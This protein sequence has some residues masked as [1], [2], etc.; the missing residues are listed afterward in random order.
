MQYRKS[1]KFAF[2]LAEVLITLGIIGVVAALTIPALLRQ[3]Q[4]QTTV[5]ILK[6]QHS[7]WANAYT[8]AVQENDTP[9]NWNLIA[10]SSGPGAANMLNMF[11]PY[12]K[13]VKNCGTAAG[14]FPS[15]IDYKYLSGTSAG[16]YDSDTTLAKAQLAD[17]S[18]I[19]ISIQDAVCNNS[20][21]AL[22]LNKI[23]ASIIVDTNG[24]K[25]PNQVGV[26]T[27][28]FY[29]SKTAVI[30][31]GAPLETAR[32][33]NTDC[34]D[35]TITTELGWGCSAWVVYNENMDYLKCPGVLSWGGT[36]KCN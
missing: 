22:P 21:G 31:G 33:F 5:A 6:K 29:V 8:L 20:R 15:N 23:C 12:I 11:A 3:Q 17:G 19:A 28:W 18:L 32:N 9:E 7:V 36:V 10:S 4:V 34:S 27:F 30:P 16:I 25:S 14:C 35:K 13:I 2:T 26:D 1:F 24:F